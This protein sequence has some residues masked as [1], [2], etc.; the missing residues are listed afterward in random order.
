MDREAG[1]VKLSYDFDEFQTL[2]L[3]NNLKDTSFDAFEVLNIGQDGTG[4]YSAS[5]TATV[6]EFMLFDGV[7][8]EEDLT[9]LAKYYGI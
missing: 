3:P 4:N 8:S 5:C 9:A 2:T 1:V 7:L 6:D